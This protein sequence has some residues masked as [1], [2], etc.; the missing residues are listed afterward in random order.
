MNLVTIFNEIHLLNEKD[1]RAMNDLASLLALQYNLP[2]RKD[3]VRHNICI[4]LL[5]WSFYQEQTNNWVRRMRALRYDAWMSP[6]SPEHFCFSSCSNIVCCAVSEG[7]VGLDVQDYRNI[8]PMA[9]AEFVSQREMEK[10]SEQKERRVVEVTRILTLKESFGKFL[11]VGLDYDVVKTNLYKEAESFQKYGVQFVS[12]FLKD[13]VISVCFEKGKEFG[14][15][16][17]EYN[18]LRSILKALKQSISL[19]ENLNGMVDLREYEPRSMVTYAGKA[20]R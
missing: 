11:G 18:E 10:L 9:L 7:N 17:I 12:Y 15:K 8:E 1:K 3:P 19:Q 20:T 13:A 6:R 2:F 5:A 4:I 16:F 14:Y